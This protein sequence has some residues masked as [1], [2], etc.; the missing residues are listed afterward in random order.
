MKKNYNQKEKYN[1]FSI[2][3]HELCVIRGRLKS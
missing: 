1:F 3:D 2:Y